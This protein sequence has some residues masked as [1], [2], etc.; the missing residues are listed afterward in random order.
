MSEQPEIFDD[1]SNPLDSVEDILAGQD[2]VFSRPRPDEL[3]VQVSGKNGIYSITFLWQEEFSV[4]QFICEYDL[5]IPSERAQLAASILRRLNENLW[6]GHF[7]I[8]QCTG[9]P[10]FRHTSMF[11]GWTHTSGA[12]HVEDLVDIALAECDRCYG[13]FAFL[14]SSPAPDESSL[15]LMLCEEAG[16]A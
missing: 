9:A 14:C 16:E 10:R 1:V 13:A 6:L 8:P 12:E 4:L 2:W 11:R 3:S 15:S 5:K 7:D